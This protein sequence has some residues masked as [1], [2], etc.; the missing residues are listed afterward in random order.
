MKRVISF[1]AEISNQSGI[2]IQLAKTLKKIY[3]F[4]N[5]FKNKSAMYKYSP[6]MQ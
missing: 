3:R 5:L 6:V 1:T 2:L 4:L